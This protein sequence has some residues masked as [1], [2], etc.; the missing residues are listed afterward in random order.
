MD[1]LPGGKAIEMTWKVETRGT[2]RNSILPT[3]SKVGWLT[4]TAESP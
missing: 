3:L 2:F 1:A 4:L